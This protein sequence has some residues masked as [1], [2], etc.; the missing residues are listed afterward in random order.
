[1]AVTPIPI[2]ITTTS[3]PNGT[4]QAAY[5]VTVTA[6]GGAGSDKWV[7][8]GLPPGLSMSAG[9]TISGT[10]TAPGLFV[11]A[12]TVTDAAG[13]V[14]VQTYTLSILLPTPP[15]LNFGNLP[16]TVNAGTQLNAQVGLASN[17]PLPVTATLTLTFTPDSGGD[18]PAVQFST[19]GRVTVVQIPAGSLNVPGGV[20]IQI[21]TVSGI[22]T[23]TADLST[24]GQDIT[25]NPAP[26]VTIRVPA[27]A[28]SITSVTAIPT[29]GGFTVTVIGF[30]TP[31]SVTQATFAF[32][33][34]SGANLQTSSLVVSVTSLFSAWYAS[35]AAAPFGSQFSFAQPFTVTGSLQGITSVT[36]TLTNAQGN[37]TPVTATLQ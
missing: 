32:A 35:P 11:V 19:G 3:L 22:I 18:D 10:P 15:T 24:A 31:R 13:T 36:V 8:T 23:I 12:V 34:A 25:P 1:L 21:G 6:S 14:A 17:Y 33:A 5:S 29:A 28:P 2:N 16:A 7:A 9:G 30:A 20:A 26:T 37:S 4:V 27:A